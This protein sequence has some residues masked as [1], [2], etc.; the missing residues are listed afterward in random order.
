MKEE[1]LRG[2]QI[3]GRGGGRRRSKGMER[4]EV[5]DSGRRWKRRERGD[6]RD[7]REIRGG[8]GGRRVKWRGMRRW[9]R[10]REGNLHKDNGNEPH[11]T[12]A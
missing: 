9:R 1:E 10:K 2:G 8:V 3:K 11:K 12:L 4:K 5:G 7:E 6:V